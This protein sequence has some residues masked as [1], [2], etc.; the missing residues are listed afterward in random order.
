MHFQQYLLDTLPG[1]FV[2]NKMLRMNEL[3]GSLAETQ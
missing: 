1:G 2:T 3:A